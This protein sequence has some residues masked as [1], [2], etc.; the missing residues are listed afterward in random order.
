MAFHLYPQLIQYL[1][2]DNW[3]GPPREVSHASTWPWIGHPVSRLRP[4]TN[5]PIKTRFRYGSEG[6][7]LNLATERNSPAHS[8][9]GTPPLRLAEANLRAMTACEHTVSGSI[10][11]PFRGSFHLS[12][13][14]LCAIGRRR[15]FSLG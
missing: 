3:F 6:S 2:N 9:T 14:V 7:P 10:S 4:M 1:F 8:S 13:T 12:L 15:V 5:R 11:L